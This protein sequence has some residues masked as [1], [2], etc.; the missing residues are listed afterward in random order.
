MMTELQGVLL[1]HQDPQY[2]LF[3][4][5]LLPELPGERI[6]GVRT[7]I[8]RSI[9]REMP[10]EAKYPFLQQLPHSWFEEY[11]IH[12]FL[13]EREKDFNTALEGVQALLPYIDNWAT[14]DQL[15][16]KAFAKDPQRLLPY[17]ESWLSSSHTYTMRF[18]VSMLMTLFLDD[19]FDPVY[20][21][22]IARIRSTDYY[23]NMMLAWYFATALAKQYDAVLP[24]LRE[25]RLDPWVHNKTIRK[26]IESYRV[27]PEHKEYLRTL[28]VKSAGEYRPKAYK[29]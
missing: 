25:Y 26:A 22:R 8:L 20:A 15:R 4:Q 1:S 7:P 29:E 13:L 19:R 18:G 23:G 17:I 11:Q 24:I 28:S 12:D 14:C 16:P 2:Q 6:L 21:E 9:A 5:K 3:Q 10:Q 27:T